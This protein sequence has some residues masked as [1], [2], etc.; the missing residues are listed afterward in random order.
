MDYKLATIHFRNSFNKQKELEAKYLRWNNG[1][2]IIYSSPEK[3]FVLATLNCSM[4]GN[5]KWLKGVINRETKTF[6]SFSY[7]GDAQ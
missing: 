2:W 5:T 3:E 7:L 6:A 4:E 1:G